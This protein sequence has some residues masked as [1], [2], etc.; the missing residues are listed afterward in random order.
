MDS[1]KIKT[2]VRL[3]LEGIGED[4][5]RPGLRKTPQRVADMYEDIFSGIGPRTRPSC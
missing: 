2:G 1:D 5:D 3:I 4:P